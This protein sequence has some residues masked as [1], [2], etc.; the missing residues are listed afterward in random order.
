VGS[1]I[2]G[3]LFLAV[4]AGLVAF[5]LP[6]WRKNRHAGRRGSRSV[7]YRDVFEIDGHPDPL[8]DHNLHVHPHVIP[9]DP[10]RDSVGTVTE[11]STYVTE[12]LGS[13]YGT[14]SFSG[15]NRSSGLSDTLN[16]SQLQ[17]GSGSGRYR[18]Y[19]NTSKYL[20]P[21]REQDAGP[22]LPFHDSGDEDEYRAVSGPSLPP[23]YSSIISTRPRQAALREEKPIIRGDMHVV[24]SH[25][26]KDS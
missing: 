26:D 13:S 17:S 25:S 4:L 10:Y 22:L 14:T 12:V 19:S 2:G 3:V 18:T 1:V 9:Y 8:S 5:F 6:R 20:A 21:L 23:L 11:Q 15:G 16:D 7:E 24:G